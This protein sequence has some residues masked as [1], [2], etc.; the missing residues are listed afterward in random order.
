VARDCGN[1]ARASLG[2]GGVTIV[3][4]ISQL[5]KELARLDI[6]DRRLVSFSGLPVMTHAFF[7]GGNGLYEGVDA[8]RMPVGGTLVLGSNFGC[9]SGF[10]NDEGQLLVLDERNNRTW[11]PLRDN[12]RDSGIK[13]EECFFTNAWPFLHEGDSNLGGMIGDWLRNP[14]LM[15]TCIRFFEYTQATLQ[16]KLIV[17]LGTGPAA[18]LSHVWPGTLG[19]WKAC[20][21]SCLDDLP[22]AAVRFQDRPVLCVATTHPSMPN[23]WRRRPPY[24]HRAGELQL[25]T[26]AR[27]KSETTAPR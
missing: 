14:P 18:F 22:M 26:E 21:I 13:A 5:R 2:D 12:L 9:R 19:L 15:K 16:P 1:G 27:V 23:S 11:S 8:V 25:L 10:I 4:I 7:P 6:A 20:A 17:A 3:Q 24:Q